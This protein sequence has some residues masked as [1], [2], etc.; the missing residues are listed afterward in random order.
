MGPRPQ[1]L[2]LRENEQIGA[3]R[4]RGLTGRESSR[5]RRLVG[6]DQHFANSR[7]SQH[8][9]STDPLEGDRHLPV[10]DAEAATAYA[11]NEPGETRIRSTVSR[12]P[13]TRVVDEIT[14]VPRAAAPAGS[15]LAADRIVEL[16]PRR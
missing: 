1:W 11:Q 13:A 9:P 5:S 7:T 3:V 12:C 10:S 14:P 16:A 6:L 15:P 2:Q 4:R 8:V